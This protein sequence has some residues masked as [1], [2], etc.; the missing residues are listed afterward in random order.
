M[1]NYNTYELT[2]I[3]QWSHWVIYMRAPRMNNKKKRVCKY[4]PCWNAIHRIG[5]RKTKIGVIFRY[6]RK[7]KK[8]RIPEPE[9]KI[10]SF[11]KELLLEILRFWH[12]AK[13]RK[14]EILPSEASYVDKQNVWEGSTKIDF[15]SIITFN[16]Q[17]LE[18][19]KVCE[20]CPKT[21]QS[22]LKH[23]M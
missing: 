20:C 4:L 2:S 21:V 13:S 12:T 8:S 22:P 3:A 9:L 19:P 10:Y 18:G 17:F 23:H 1:F 16:I 14:S 6:H 5:Q 7:S 11:L 15:S